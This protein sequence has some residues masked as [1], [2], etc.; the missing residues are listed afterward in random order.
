MVAFLI[1]YI[2]KRHAARAVKNQKMTII[3]NIN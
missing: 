1:N 2:T 3:A